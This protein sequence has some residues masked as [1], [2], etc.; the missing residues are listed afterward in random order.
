MQP[1]MQ[2]QLAEIRRQH[3][4]RNARQKAEG[5]AP[6][7]PKEKKG[8]V[9]GGKYF[10]DPPKQIQM[11]E[12]EEIVNKYQRIMR[13][14]KS[15][16]VTKVEVDSDTADMFQSFLRTRNFSFLRAAILYGTVKDG[17]SHVHTCYEPEQECKPDH[18]KLLPDSRIEKA[19]KVAKLLG[20][21]RVGLMVSAPYAS[22]EDPVLTAQEVLLCAEQQAKYGHHCCLVQVRIG[23]DQ[24]SI[25]VEGYQVS[26]QCVDIFREGTLSEGATPK[27]VHSERELEAVQEVCERGFKI[28]NF[29]FH[30][31]KR[32]SLAQERP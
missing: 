11:K 29:F 24:Q 3:A 9:I 14:K 13:Q 17:V 27:F 16:T 1:S 30:N 19:D 12:Y 28:F 21:Q 5:T 4:E 26:K 22:P 8:K 7:A 18:L 23:Q 10:S 2:E 31:R 25:N 6:A 20:L 32:A 15:D